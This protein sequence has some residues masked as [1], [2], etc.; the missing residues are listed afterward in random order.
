MAVWITIVLAAV[1]P[2]A[3]AARTL[4]RRAVIAS[5]AVSSSVKGASAASS[6]ESS[7][8]LKLSVTGMKWSDLRLGQGAAPAK[9]QEVTIDYMMTRR[10]GAKI[11]STIDSRQPFT[12]TVGDGTVIEG[13]EAA[14]LGGADMPP[15]RQGG[16][17]RV[18]IPQYLAYGKEKGLFASGAP[19]EIQKLQPIPPD[20]WWTPTGGGDKVNAY[21][22]F[23]NIYLDEN[24]LDQPDLILDISLRAVGEAPSR[25]KANS[26]GSGTTTAEPP[27]ALSSPTDTSEAA[28]P[29]PAPPPPASVGSP[30]VDDALAAKRLELLRLQQENLE[31]EIALMKAAETKWKKYGFE[32]GGFGSPFSPPNYEK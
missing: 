3:A 12:W 31:K 32:D 9:G 6:L 29:A 20:F 2:A 30:S 24:R 10:A 26:A 18:M 14:V 17:R 27:Q 5:A 28:V 8:D 1:L 15:L 11:Y 19:T 23:R 4:T 22:R 25:S 13:L 16:A 7:L 21:L